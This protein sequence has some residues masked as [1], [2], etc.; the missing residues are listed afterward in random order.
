MLCAKGRLFPAA[1][2]RAEGA[3]VI[4]KP[5]LKNIFDDEKKISVIWSDGCFFIVKIAGTG[6]QFSK[7]EI[8]EIGY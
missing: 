8:S 7:K 2:N 1:R 3:G 5:F 4:N 6:Q